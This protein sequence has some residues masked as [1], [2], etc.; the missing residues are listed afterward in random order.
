MV[1]C[2]CG[3]GARTP[4]DPSASTTVMLC[5]ACACGWPCTAMGVPTPCVDNVAITAR[6]GL[7]D[8]VSLEGP[9]WYACAP[10][11]RDNQRKIRALMGGVGKEAGMS[12]PQR[13][14]GPLAVAPLRGRW[15]GAPPQ[16]Q[17]TL[18]SLGGLEGST[19][20]P[21]VSCVPWCVVC[22]C[23]SGTF[24]DLERRE[25]PTDRE[26]QIPGKQR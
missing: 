2:C 25:Q 1:P 13:T 6:V 17:Q 8:A 22:C 24:M 20:P 21:L 19:K 16:A 10:F 18:G 12:S 5:G 3:G 9:A 7:V 26:K 11:A 14:F 15:T 4:M 23:V